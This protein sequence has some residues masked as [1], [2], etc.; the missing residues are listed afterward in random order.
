MQAAETNPNI[1]EIHVQDSSTNLVK[2][3][4]SCSFPAAVL[5][6]LDPLS[7]LGKVECLYRFFQGEVMGD[8]R[9]NVDLPC[10]QH[11]DN[12]RP[13]T[14]SMEHRRPFNAG[15]EILKHP[16]IIHNCLWHG[17]PNGHLLDKLEISLITMQL[18]K[19]KFYQKQEW[20]P[21]AIVWILI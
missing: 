17:T 6:D 3:L 19:Y 11:V 5:H 12:R 13:P 15:G 2:V 18:I 1:T 21:V 14:T 8:D 10:G 4:T 9:L 16:I 20:L 7:T